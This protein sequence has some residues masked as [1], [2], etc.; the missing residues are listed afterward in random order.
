[1]NTLSA[2]PLKSVATHPSPWSQV[3]AESLDPERALFLGGVRA[4]VGTLDFYAG[5]LAARDPGA[6][7]AVAGLGILQVVGGGVECMFGVMEGKKMTAM[8]GLGDM[9]AGGGLLAASV[10]VVLIGVGMASLGTV[11]DM[12]LNSE[13]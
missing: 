1:M 13:K 5:S 2:E 4:G 8:Q 12:F 6:L 3:K 7:G 11:G 9:I 10:P